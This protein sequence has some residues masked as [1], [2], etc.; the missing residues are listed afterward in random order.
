MM[1]WL[2]LLCLLIPT[3][4]HA[5]DGLDV[6][7]WLSRPGVKVLATSVGTPPSM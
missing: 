5:G 2:L 7:G 3:T 6:R 4:A 1:R